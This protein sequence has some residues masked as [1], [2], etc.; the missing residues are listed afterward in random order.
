MPQVLPLKKKK[1]GHLEK[2]LD[3][4]MEYRQ[5]LLR[6]L[7]AKELGGNVHSVY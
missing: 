6:F 5:A 1:V 4:E 3:M 2:D 7:G